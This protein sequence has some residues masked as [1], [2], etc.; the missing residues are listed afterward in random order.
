M[1]LARKAESRREQMLYESSRLGLASPVNA[2][3]NGCIETVRIHI[4]LT[5]AKCGLM[6]RRPPSA[7]AG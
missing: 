6:F 7:T 1:A 3:W 4:D 5:L 2:K